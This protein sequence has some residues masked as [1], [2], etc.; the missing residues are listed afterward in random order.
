LQERKSKILCI[1]D[2]SDTCLMISTWLESAS[3]EVKSAVSI[4]NGVAFAQEGG[5]NLY[6]LIQTLPGEMMIDLCRKMRNFDPQTPILF[7][8]TIIQDEDNLKRALEAGAQ[9]YLKSSAN[10]SDLAETI[11][12]LL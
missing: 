1:A 11:S 9:G 5:F 6:L 10:L 2:D 4:P 12:R 7:Y 8:S 3:Y